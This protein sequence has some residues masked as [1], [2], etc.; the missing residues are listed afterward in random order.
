VW[1]EDHRSG[2][3][4]YRGILMKAEKEGVAGAIGIWTKV[5]KF[6]K[7]LKCKALDDAVTHSEVS[8]LKTAFSVYEWTPGPKGHG[9]IKF[10]YVCL[11]IAKE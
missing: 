1:I 8:N 3:P 7:K 2:S 10:V 5:P 11:F 6:T 4:G 9:N